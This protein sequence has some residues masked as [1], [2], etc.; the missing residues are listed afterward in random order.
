ME[1]SLK[2]IKRTC[3]SNRDLRV[4]HFLEFL[5]FVHFALFLTMTAMFWEIFLASGCKTTHIGAFKDCFFTLGISSANT[6][7]NLQLGK[8]FFAIWTTFTMSKFVNSRNMVIQSFFW[9][10]RLKTSWA[11]K[12]TWSFM[13]T[14]CMHVQSFICFE[15][16]FTFFTC[17][18][19]FTWMYWF[20]VDIQCFLPPIGIATNMTS[21]IFFMYTFHMFFKNS[22]SSY[23]KDTK[24]TRLALN[25]YSDT[26]HLHKPG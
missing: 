11:L 2:I 17:N 20:N 15:G 7:M 5:L 8:L 23:N 18:W 9:I 1:K 14:P 12:R 19:S 3:S 21:Q 24:I 25:L 13:C 6:Y 16:S 10:E 4:F 26:Y 22:F